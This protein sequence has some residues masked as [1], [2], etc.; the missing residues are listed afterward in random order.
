[1]ASKIAESLEASWALLAT[2]TPGTPTSSLAEY[3]AFFEPD[4]VVHLM[5][6]T[7]PPAVGREAIITTLQSILTSWDLVERKVVT[8]VV[9]EKRRTVANSMSNKLRIRD[10]VLDAFLECEVVSFSE[11]GLVQKYELYTDPAPI[12]ALLGGGS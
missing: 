7:A 4:A 6:I 1:M 8:S 3:A 9:D 10:K 11:R 12:L 5:G 2:F